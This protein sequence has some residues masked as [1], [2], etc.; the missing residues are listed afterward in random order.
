LL[1]VTGGACAA[2][3]GASAQ[4]D[5][6]WADG[7]PALGSGVQ[8]AAVLGEKLDALL[9]P[10]RA[11]TMNGERASVEVFDGTAR[12]VVDVRLGLVSDVDVEV[13]SD[14]NDGQLLILPN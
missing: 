13:L 7:P 8:V 5:V 4:I 14:L 11:V 9:I 6:D 3:A 12:R 10:R 1:F 2:A